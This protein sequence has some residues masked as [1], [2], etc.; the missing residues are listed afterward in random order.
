MRYENLTE[1]KGFRVCER[2][3]GYEG[4]TDGGG[5]RG[6]GGQGGG[7][8]RGNITYKGHMN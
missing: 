5:R 1:R 7:G 2:Q 6:P 8:R 3:E 4:L